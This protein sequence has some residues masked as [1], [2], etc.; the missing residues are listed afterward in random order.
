MAKAAEEAKLAEDEAK[1]MV[2]KEVELTMLSF[3]K[4]VIWLGWQIRWICS[5]MQ[6]ALDVRQQIDTRF[7]MLRSTP[8]VLMSSLT[9]ESVKDLMPV[10]FCARDRWAQKVNTGL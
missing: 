10:V 8:V 5:L 3:G 2:E 6:Y 7:P 4:A 9:G 1:S